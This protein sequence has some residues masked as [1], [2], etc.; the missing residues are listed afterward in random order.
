MKRAGFKRAL[1][2]TCISAEGA[3]GSPLYVLAERDRPLVAGLITKTVSRSD[4]DAT[5]STWGIAVARGFTQVE[6]ERLQAV[7]KADIRDAGLVGCD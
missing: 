6:L 1:V 5:E 2:S 4:P 3:S 7:I